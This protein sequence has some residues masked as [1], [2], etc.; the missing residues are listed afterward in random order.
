MGKITEL[1][2]SQIRAKMSAFQALNSPPPKS[3]PIK[4]EEMILNNRL[5]V[6]IHRDRRGVSQFF[7]FIK[8]HLI[9]GHDNLKADGKTYQRA[10][11][12]DD[13]GKCWQ[14]VC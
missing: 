5:P 10:A 4:G 2:A 13:I 12:N 9:Q 6:P 1:F 7:F 14:P 11:G 8:P 3:S